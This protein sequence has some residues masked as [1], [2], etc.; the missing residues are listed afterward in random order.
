MALQYESLLL[1]AKPRNV[2]RILD[3]YVEPFTTGGKTY[4]RAVANWW[5]TPPFTYH[6]YFGGD[7]K[8]QDKEGTITGTTIGKYGI[9]FGIDHSDEIDDIEN[10]ASNSVL[11]ITDGL[12]TT[13]SVT[14]LQVKNN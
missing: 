6:F 8:I 4:Y 11:V 12:G 5:G 2:L 3:A 7:V 14:P 10:F 13:K 1:A 9:S